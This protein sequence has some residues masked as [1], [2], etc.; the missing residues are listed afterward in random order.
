MQLLAACLHSQLGILPFCPQAADVDHGPARTLAE[1]LGD[2]AE[3][4]FAEQLTGT[5]VGRAERWAPGTRAGAPRD[6]NHHTKA[7]SRPPARHPQLAR[8]ATL[9]AALPAASPVTRRADPPLLAPLPATAPGGGVRA[10]PRCWCA[11]SQPL[12]RSAHR[13]SPLL[14]PA[15]R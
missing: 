15:G 8:P 7:W 14:L 6:P 13:S 1:A 9:P 3:Y 2:L 4:Q 11:L 10:T 12:R 5:D